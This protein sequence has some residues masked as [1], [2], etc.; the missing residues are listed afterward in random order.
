[1]DSQVSEA[2]IKLINSIQRGERPFSK[3]TLYEL[4]DVHKDA[5]KALPGL[6][7]LILWLTTS[8]ILFL[9][10]NLESLADGLRSLLTAHAKDVVELV[11]TVAITLS[12][13]DMT[14][15]VLSLCQTVMLFA[16]ENVAL[17]GVRLRCL[18]TILRLVPFGTESFVTRLKTP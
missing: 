3:H 16:L 2:T 13:S 14:G 6:A 7:L 11:D 15:V 18:E 9:G 10:E 1:M 8:D 5:G 17:K 4:L 12:R